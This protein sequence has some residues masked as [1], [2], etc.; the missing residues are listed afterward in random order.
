MRKRI[1]LIIVFIVL[2]ALFWV[3]RKQTPN[4]LPTGRVYA[5]RVATAAGQTIAIPVFI[6]SKTAAIN[7]A[8]IYISFDPAQVQVESIDTTGSF[9][10]L[11]I[12]NNPQF[13]NKDG[14][15]VLAGGLPTPGHSGNGLVATINAKVIKRGTYL[16]PFTD[17]SRILINDGKGTTQPLA[18]PPIRFIGR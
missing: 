16:L 13:S 9:F 7:A 3:W 18:K 1:V 14:T 10:T 11:W 15:I 12:A 5:D 2:L 8:E 17:K 6:D 4:T